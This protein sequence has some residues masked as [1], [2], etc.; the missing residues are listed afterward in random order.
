[1]NV[2][3]EQAYQAARWGDAEFDGILTGAIT[4]ADAVERH[5]D[6]IIKLQGDHDAEM[7]HMRHLCA[8]IQRDLR[9]ARDGKVRAEERMKGMS[10]II[11]R[12]SK[13]AGNSEECCIWTQDPIDDKWDTG[14]GKGW[15]THDMYDRPADVFE[16]C[17]YCG[18]RIVEA[19]VSDYQEQ[20]DRIV[21]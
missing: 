14:C 1:V 9:Y 17:P 21:V 2:I 10:R 7:E 18:K 12:L 19:G 8:D 16:Y 5:N 6:A 3:T 4:P 13:Q 20:A 15:M 11:T